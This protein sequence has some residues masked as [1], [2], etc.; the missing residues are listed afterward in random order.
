MTTYLRDLSERVGAAFAFGLLAQLPQQGFDVRQWPWA[1]SL[2]LAA[3]FSVLTLLA[4]IAARYKGSP[5]TAGFTD[6]RK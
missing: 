2:S 3:S 4:G 5:A 6:P 1:D